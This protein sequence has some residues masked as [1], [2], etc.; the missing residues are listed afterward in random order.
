MRRTH[1]VACRAARGTRTARARRRRRSPRRAPRA[2]CRRAPSRARRA[3]PACRLQRR[4]VEAR[5]APPA[6]RDSASSFSTAP[7]AI[8]RLANA[9]S[10]NAGTSSPKKYAPW[11][12]MSPN[13]LMRSPSASTMRARPCA[14]SATMPARARGTAARAAPSRRA[15]P[16]ACSAS[17][18]PAA[19]PGRSWPA[20]CC[21]R[22]SEKFSIICVAREELG[23]VVE[24][25]AEQH[26]V[27]DDRVGQVADLLVEVDDHRVE[28]LGRDAR[29]HRRGDLRAVLVDLL[30]VGVLQILCRACAWTA[31][32]S[33]PA[34][35]R[36]AGARTPAAG[37]RA[38]GR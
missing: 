32:A 35:R 30:E 21:T 11:I 8:T 13:T 27:V 16:A 36:T 3:T 19:W 2:R 4:R 18:T 29:A 25:P 7:G 24:R 5:R 17:G 1:D 10:S 37:S 14:S 34:R 26:Q 9:L 15:A 6:S 12:R 23:L 20:P 31:C 38:P 28:R 33:S 22:S